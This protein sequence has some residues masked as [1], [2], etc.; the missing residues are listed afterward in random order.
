[1]GCPYASGLSD[2]PE[3]TAP[4]GLATGGGEFALVPTHPAIINAIADAS[5]IRIYAIPAIPEKML[6]ALNRT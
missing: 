1:M 2:H 6:A 5:G 3:A 4:W